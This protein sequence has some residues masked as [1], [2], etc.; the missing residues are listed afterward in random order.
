MKQ[1]LAHAAHL[2]DVRHRGDV[3]DLST[4][5]EI[6]AIKNTSTKLLADER[7]A[8][9]DEAPKNFLLNLT[10]KTKAAKNAKKAALIGIEKSTTNVQ[11]SNT[12]SGVPLENV[13]KFK[14]Q[15]GFTQAVRMPCS[16]RD[17]IM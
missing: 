8:V 3:N 12:G 15:K 5:A 9:T 17:F 16:T 1:L 2:E 14:Y 10:L 4:D 6:V 13:V 11:L 7:D